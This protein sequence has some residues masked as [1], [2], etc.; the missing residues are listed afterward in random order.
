MNIKDLTPAQRAAIKIWEQF[1]A[2]AFLN[3]ILAGVA[4]LDS[5]KTIDVKMLIT[6][7]LS[8]ALLALCNVA[9]KYLKASGQLPLSIMVSTAATEIASRAPATPVYTPALQAAQTAVSDLFSSS[10]EP[11]AKGSDP[12]PAP[13]VSILDEP[14]IPVTTLP[15]ISA[16]K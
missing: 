5:F 3:G 12:V 1:I 2:I 4:Y 10:Q 11:A 14:A 9:T 6:V 13:I 8:Q 15:N 16:V 7:V